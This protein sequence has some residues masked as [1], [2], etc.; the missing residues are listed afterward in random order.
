MA[1]FGGAP[2]PGPGL[3]P[4]FPGEAPAPIGRIRTARPLLALSFDDG[5][6]AA[7]TPRV[8]DA[9]ASRRVRA[10]FFVLGERAVRNPAI[11]RRMLAEG[12][13]IGNHTWSHP[14]LRGLPDA[15]LLDEIDRTATT[16]LD[17]VGRRPVLLRPPYGWISPAQRQLIHAARGLPTVLWSV[18]PEDWRS[19]PPAVVTRRILDQARPGAIVL[20]HDTI[21][22][23]LEALPT[24]LDGLI[25]RGFAFVTVSELIALGQG[26]RGFVKS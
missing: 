14:R 10:T 11:L 9:L 18:D 24:T 2:S 13:E 12:H 25:E 16:V 20:S 7:L 3:R 4:A 15:A 19:P 17:A 23:T 21:A 6:H 8:L 26:G 22:A 5:P 1:Q